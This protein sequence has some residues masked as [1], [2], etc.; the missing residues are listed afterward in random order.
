[1]FN[2]LEKINQRPKA[3]EFYTAEELWTDEYT[4]KRML[5]FHLNESVDLSSRNKKFIEQSLEWIVTR[6]NVTEETKIAD[7]GCGPGLY[8]TQLAEKGANITG[9]DFSNNS[10]QYAKN[11]SEQK[12]LNINYIQKNYLEFETEERF[13]LIIMIMC[14]FCALSPAQRKTLLKKFNNFLKP[15]GSVLLDVYS[16]NAYDK[17]EE[18]ATYEH[19]L[20]NGFWSSE[21]YYGFLNIFK[22]K[23]E[24]VILDKYTIIERIR[25]RVVYNWLQY[26]SISSLNKLFQNNG[27]RIEEF[28]SDIAG[29][30]YSPESDE[31]A[32]VAQKNNL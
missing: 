24:R 1:M 26:F 9:I 7:F 22:Y 28:Y 30:A 6:F 16:L 17:R 31:I 20:L 3:F 14:D 11:I 19:N 8:T 18:K 27:F 10:I 29:K 15:G 23:K 4:S 13:D 12:R 32:I 25:T 2:N 21:K 5:E